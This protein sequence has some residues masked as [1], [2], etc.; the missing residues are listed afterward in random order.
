MYTY[1]YICTNTHIYTHIY[2]YICCDFYILENL[3]IKHRCTSL[4]GILGPPH[5]RKIGFHLRLEA[6]RGPPELPS[7]KLG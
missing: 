2:I 4:T 5:H 6:F 1:I 3:S 7:T